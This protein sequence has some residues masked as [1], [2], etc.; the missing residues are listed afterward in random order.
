MTRHTQ[1]TGNY[2]FASL[3]KYYDTEENGYGFEMNQVILG[4]T[5]DLR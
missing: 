5:T 3:L 1:F 4:Q 2:R